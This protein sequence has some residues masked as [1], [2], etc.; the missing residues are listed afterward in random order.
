M[1]YYI[2]YTSVP[3][4]EVSQKVVDEIT[5]KSIAWNTDHGITG[6]LL[7]M[8]NQFLQLLEG[9]ENDVNEIFEKIRQDPRHQNV[10]VRIRGYSDDRVFSEWS[11]GSWMLSNENLNELSAL[12]DLKN[13]LADPVN[14]SLQSKKY[15]MM[16][17]NLLKTWIAHE[18]ERAERLKGK[19]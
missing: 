11:M 8:E 13:P 2:I 12:E 6:M 1:I 14:T 19:S 3:S 5:D 9:D 16:M 7:C 10:S 15:F 17:D 4:G 18:P